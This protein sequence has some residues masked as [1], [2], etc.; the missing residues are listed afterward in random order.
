M[1]T[2]TIQLPSGGEATIK[3]CITNRERARVAE[4]SQKNRLIEELISITMLTYKES[5][6]PEAVKKFF[7]STDGRDFTEIADAVSG[8][9]EGSA[10][11][12]AE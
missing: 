4:A 8:L 2:K 12:K 3:T 9:F 5:S 1:E 11:P 10:D 6:G 7:D